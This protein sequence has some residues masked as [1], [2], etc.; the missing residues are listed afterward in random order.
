MFDDLSNEEWLAIRLAEA[1]LIDPATAEVSCDWGY[2]VDP[3]GI[4]PDLPEECKC[5][6]RLDFARRPGRDIWVCFYDL[7]K[8][9]LEALRKRLDGENANAMADEE[10]LWL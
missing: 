4:D 3:Y 7:P 9:V 10:L 6:G 2:I 1:E 8:D 5:V